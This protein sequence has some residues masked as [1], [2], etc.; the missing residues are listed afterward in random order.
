V[1]LVNDLHHM[2]FLTADMDRLIAFYE[3]IFDARVTLDRTDD[4]RRHAFIEIG[5]HT[6]LHPFEV[7]GA[8][9]PGRQPIFQR[10]RLDHFALNA[11][12][13]EAFREIRRRLI[14]EGANATEGGLV[15]DMGS[16]LSFSFHDPDG[17]WHEV[18]WVKPGVSEELERPSGWKMID[19]D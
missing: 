12:D 9:V 3:R 10:G 7:T 11:V 1:A 5:P 18:I 8:D 6:V 2:T 19:L 15:T 16:L 4:G 17:G 14:A 13:E